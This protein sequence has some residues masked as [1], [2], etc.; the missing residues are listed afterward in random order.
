MGDKNNTEVSSSKI[1]SITL[2]IIFSAIFIYYITL[3]NSFSASDYEPT[4]NINIITKEGDH[5][6]L[7]EE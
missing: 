5:F 3:M 4:E 2:L 6:L 7:Y 1:A